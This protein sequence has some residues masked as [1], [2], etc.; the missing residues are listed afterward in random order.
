MHKLTFKS[1]EFP[2]MLA[3][4]MK[5]PRKIPYEKTTPPIMVYG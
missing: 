4:M 2:R 1:D 3:H 5:H